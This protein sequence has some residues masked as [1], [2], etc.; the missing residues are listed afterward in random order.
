M[1]CI[2]FAH[3]KL[4]FEFN[5][6]INKSDKIKIEGANG[7]GKSTFS[8]VLTTLYIPNSGII[9]IN[10]KDRK[11]YNQEKI[12]DKILLVST[13]DILF[14]ETIKNNICLGKEIPIVEILNK[15][16]Q[17][18]FYDFIASK[19]DGLEFIISENG[20][21]LSTGQRKKILLLRTIFSKAEIV[22]LDEVLSGMDT[23]TREKVEILIEND[24]SKT[25]IIIS[26]ESIL[27]INFNKKYKIQDGELFLL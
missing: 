9:L 12:K 6:Q 7:S 14:N 17:I 1:P 26:H 8:K 24:H 4:P 11:F 15:A 22:I 13:E 27:N 18:N 3:K 16:K 5:L 2:C 20:K 23:E 19:E 21:N 25:Y 10:E